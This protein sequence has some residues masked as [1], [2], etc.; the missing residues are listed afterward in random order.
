VLILCFYCMREMMRCITPFHHYCPGPTCDPWP[1][2]RLHSPAD[3]TPA[4]RM[5]AWARATGPTP[6]VLCM[7]HVLFGIMAFLYRMFSSGA[8]VIV[9]T[10]A[11]RHVR[12]M[13]VRAA[14]IGRTSARLNKLNKEGGRADGRRTH[15]GR[16]EEHTEE[17][18][19]IRTH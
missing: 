18:L 3:F 13:F 1:L 10:C 19:Y 17:Y 12:C 8:E 16:T 11:V 6:S 4:Q 15:G 9:S 7:T 14:L 2:F 5:G